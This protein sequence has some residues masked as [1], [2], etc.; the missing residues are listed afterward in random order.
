MKNWKS[1]MG[2]VVFAAGLLAPFS[3]FAVKEYGQAGCGL[4][5]VIIGDTPG[6]MQTFAATSNG[7]TAAR[8]A[9][10]TTATARPGF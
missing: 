8:S 5:A 9:Y 1:A 7:D 3:A 4:G 10:A 2:A 6:M